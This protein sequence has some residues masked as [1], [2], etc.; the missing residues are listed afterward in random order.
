MEE[1]VIAYGWR[2]S[3]KQN[4]GKVISELFV[5]LLLLVLY[6]MSKYILYL[7]LIGII[8]L[9]LIATILE[10][11]RKLIFNNKFVYVKTLLYHKII[12]LDDLVSIEKERYY[13]TSSKNS[14][15]IYYL[16]LAIKYIQNNRIKRISIP[17]QIKEEYSIKRTK[18]ITY[19]TKEDMDKID[20]VIEMYKNIN[21]DLKEMEEER[22]EKSQKI[23]NIILKIYGIILIGIFLFYIIYIGIF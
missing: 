12:N 4:K 5:C 9:V 22:N 3:L 19:F 7:A 6:I 13:S 10:G 2:D 20:K 17:L 18:D 16:N 14:R 23:F 21:I 15:T 1:I 8:L 11:E